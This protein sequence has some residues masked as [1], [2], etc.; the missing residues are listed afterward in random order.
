MSSTSCR[1]RMFKIRIAV[2][3][4][5]ISRHINSSRNSK[6]WLVEHM[7]LGRAAPPSRKSRCIV[8]RNLLRWLKSLFIHFCSRIRT[9]KRW[10]LKIWKLNR[11][12]RPSQSKWAWR[13]KSEKCT[14]KSWPKLNLEWCRWIMETNLMTFRYSKNSSSTIKRGFLN[15]AH[16]FK[17]TFLKSAPFRIQQPM[18]FLHRIVVVWIPRLAL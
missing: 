1:P 12:R 18:G 13:T 6:L 5:T 16:L 2:Y 10:T 7:T 8:Q 14:K 4:A 9:I 3:W 17:K 15:L 11:S